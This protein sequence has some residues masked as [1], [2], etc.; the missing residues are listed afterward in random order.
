[1]RRVVVVPARMA[2]TRLPAK[3]LS[4]IEGVPMIVRVLER[5]AARRWY[6]RSKVSE[7]EFTLAQ[8]SSSGIDFARKQFIQVEATIEA[9]IEAVIQQIYRSLL[10]FAVFFASSLGSMTLVS[11]IVDFL[12]VRAPAASRRPIF[13]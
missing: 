5:A 9:Q 8:R 4:D 13:A 1:M 6:A 3:P 12:M 11:L 10:F 7:Y 2:S